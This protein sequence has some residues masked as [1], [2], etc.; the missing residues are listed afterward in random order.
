MAKKKQKKS[1]NSI[2]HPNV[3]RARASNGTRMF[4]HGLDLLRLVVLHLFL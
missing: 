1:V 3:R 2:T 4:A